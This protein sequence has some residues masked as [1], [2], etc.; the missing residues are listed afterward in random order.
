MRNIDITELNIVATAG[1]IQNSKTNVVGN[2]GWT[3]SFGSEQDLKDLLNG[4]GKQVAWWDNVD[5]Q[6]E[7]EEYYMQG[8]C[9]FKNGKIYDY[10]GA[11]E[12]PI[13]GILDTMGVAWA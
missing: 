1:N 10:D 4:E 2:N 3:L 6:G 13:Q 8:G 7:E 5:G 12:L 11:H 9:W